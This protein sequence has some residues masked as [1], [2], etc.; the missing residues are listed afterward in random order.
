[1]ASKSFSGFHAAIFTF[2]EKAHNPKTQYSSG[3]RSQQTPWRKCAL[4]VERKRE[5]KE[6][7][8]AY[9]TGEGF[10]QM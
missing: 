6:N 4:K 3:A 1:M 8:Y 10:V 7:R 5:R 9:G 2:R